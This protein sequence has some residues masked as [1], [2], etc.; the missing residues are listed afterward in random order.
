[1][2]NR[3]QFVVHIGAAALT[4]TLPI[5]RLAAAV[6]SCEPQ[7]DRRPAKTPIAASPAAIKLGYAAITW[8]GDDLR[9]ID[10]IASIGFRG[11]QLRSNVLTRFGDR[12]AEL[13]KLLDQHRLTLV[14]L[15][16]GAAKI[17]PALRNAMLD[18]H[19]SH[20]KFVRDVGGLYL[21][22]TDERPK[23]RAVVS[24]DYV[25]LGHLLTEIGKRAGDLGIPLGYHN[26]MNSLGERPEEVDRILD[27]AD[28]RFV[29]FEL[30]IAHYQQGGGDPVRAIR[31]YAERLLF[32]HIKDVESPVPGDPTKAYQFVELGRG[33]VDVKGVFAALADVKF[34]GWAVIELDAVPDKARTPKES[35]LICK[36]YLEQ[37]IGLRIPS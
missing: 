21:Q 18:E 36:E 5:E 22:M 29:K 31:K 1:M 17:D 19:T 2:T 7:T 26:H 4:S 9:A 24:D 12:P 15:S 11:I 35:A 10:D 8:G 13:R 34:S 32:L 20:A 6:A 25:Q 30:D 16:S 3:R 27:A 14:A 37:Q 23:G 33:K 28:P